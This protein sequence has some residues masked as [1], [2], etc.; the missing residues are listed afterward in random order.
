MSR[1][2]SRQLLESPHFWI[3]LALI[4]IFWPAAWLHWGLLGEY[5]FFPLWLGYILAVDALVACRRGSSLLTCRPA[6]FIALFAL[7]APVWWIFEGGNN[8]TLNWHYLVDK[9]YSP[10][11]IIVESTIDF[12]TVI[13]A[14]FETASLVLTFD[15]VRRWQRPGFRHPLSHGWLWFL[16][17][18]GAFMFLAA[19][20]FPTVAFPFIW[21]WLFLL[22]DPLN[23]LC[24]R[25]SLLEQAS[26]GDF[27]AAGA[28]GIGVL[29]CAFF[30]EMWNYY[31]MPKWFYTV[32]YFD[33]KIFEMPAA[34]YLGYIPFSWELYAL[35]QY[36]VGLLRIRNAGSP[37]D[38]TA[39]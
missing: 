3:G 4:A 34:G 10:L 30:W 20:L 39:A 31:S 27:R 18:V 17:Y 38:E 22:V 32:P 8:F 19:I 6:L 11:H 15:F 14:V 35:Y 21:T 29:I 9:P 36:I 13:P 24:G 16:M 7:S 26:R 33:N 37:L 12:S 25:P 28:L 2:S 5:A 1:A 23:A